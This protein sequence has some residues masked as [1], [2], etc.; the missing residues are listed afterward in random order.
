MF[1]MRFLFKIDTLRFK[2]DAGYAL[3]VDKAGQTHA[4]GSQKCGRTE[5]VSRV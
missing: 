5:H 1:V 2:G 4:Q 3:F